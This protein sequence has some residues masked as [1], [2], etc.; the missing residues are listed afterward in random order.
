[1]LRGISFSGLFILALLAAHAWVRSEVLWRFQL[2]LATLEFGHWLA[3]GALGLAALG[4]PKGPGIWRLALGL[5]GITLAFIF[6]IPAFQASRLSPGFS[7]ARL[8]FPVARPGVTVRTLQ[9]E[10]EALKL[11]AYLPESSTRP[12]SWVLMLHSGGWNGGAPDEFP[13]WNRELTSHGIAVL[14]LGYRL[15]PKHQWPAQRDDVHQAVI[16]VRAHAAELNI[17]PDR[18]IVMG[19]S[20]G[21]QIATASVLGLPE[22]EARGC[23]A[24]YA[25]ADLFLARKYAR[26]DDILNSLKLVREYLGGDPQD[27]AQNYH[28]SSAIELIGPKTPPILLL[29]G[30]PDT[31]VWVEQ[32]RRF[33]RR[34]QEQGHD[35]RFVEL[36]WATHA[37][38]YFPNT[39]GGQVAMQEV[40]RFIKEVISSPASTSSR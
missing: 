7:W 33:H 39:P 26:E 23:I 20:A 1:M 37:C 15:A 10:G 28:T 3:L 38:D 16:W 17:D 13:E 18:L 36:P 40:V 8:W 19:R 5:S 4:M 30:T 34:L 32:S 22:L 9:T 27:Q 25:P 2:T 29:H 14:S 21:G 31:L 35:E 12:V 24:F 6:L 11:I